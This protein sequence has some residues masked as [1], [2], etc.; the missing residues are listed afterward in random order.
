M[1]N[2]FTKA[3]TI[4]EVSKQI[5]VPAGTL[6]QWEKDLKGLLQIPRSKNGARFYTDHE[7]KLLTKIKEMRDNN[8][9]QKMIHQLLHA[10]LQLEASKSDEIKESENQ[11]TAIEEFKTE[12]LS[13]IKNE[14][15][16]SIRKEVVD[17]V[18]REI[19]KGALY[20]VKNLSDSIYKS[21]EKTKAEIHSL[22]DRIQ[23]SSEQTSEVVGTLSKRV[24]RASKRHS[25]HFHAL[26]KRISE[27]SEASSEEFKTMIHYISSSA[28]VTSGEMSTL[29]ETLNAD[30]EIYIESIQKEREMYWQQV[31]ER[32]DRFQNFIESFRKTAAAEEAPQKN[33][34]QFWK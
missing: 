6:R 8:L 19:S 20:T 9:S 3:Y 34:W 22:S 23:Q 2:Q 4:N 26:T 33:W 1:T 25:E 16:M 29:I 24:S 10:H 27:S 31:R 28:E 5:G 30:R 7:I 21:S 14:I 11:I 32:E 12:L 13:E 18:K 17:E 15:V